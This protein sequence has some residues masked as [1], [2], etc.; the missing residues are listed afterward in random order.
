M[1]RFNPEKNERDFKRILTRL[2]KS[3]YTRLTACNNAFFD[4]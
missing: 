3:I 2:F 4:D 1:K